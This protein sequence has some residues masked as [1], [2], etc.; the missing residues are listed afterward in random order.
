ML[1]GEQF[2][3]KGHNDIFDLAIKNDFDDLIY[4]DSDILWNPEDLIKLLE[5]NGIKLEDEIQKNGFRAWKGDGFQIEHP[6]IDGN[7]IIIITNEDV[8]PVDQDKLKIFSNNAK[9]TKKE[10]KYIILIVIIFITNIYKICFKLLYITLL[11]V[12]IE[13][14]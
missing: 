7:D 3:E 14:Y 13:C 10:I 6:V 5:H 11:F 4:I 9:K 1:K 8:A 2:I 12:K